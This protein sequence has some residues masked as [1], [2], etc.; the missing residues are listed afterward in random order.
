M[1][2]T[3]PSPGMVVQGV[4]TIARAP[5]RIALQSMASGLGARSWGIAITIEAAPIPRQGE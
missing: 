2:V 1:W 4:G 5:D 3:V